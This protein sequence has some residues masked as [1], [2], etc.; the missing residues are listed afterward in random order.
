MKTC[1]VYDSKYGNTETVAKAMGGALPGSVKVLRAEKDALSDLKAGDLLILG[2]PTWGGKPT[3][4]VQAVLQAVPGDGLKGVRTAAF[5][6]RVS[7]PV[8]KLFGNAAV[9]I[10][11]ALQKKGG[12]P[13]AGP[14]GF[15]VEKSRGPLRSGEKERAAQW[16]KSIATSV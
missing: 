7:N 14:E 13:A 10:A 1:I 3:Q 15:F 4:A 6:T 16:A 2:S 9:K 5:D 12:T 8:A 11:D